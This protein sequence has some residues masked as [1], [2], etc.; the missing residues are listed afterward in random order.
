V[1]V[2]C[3]RD[4]SSYESFFV[5]DIELAEL[6][7]IATSPELEQLLAGVLLEAPASSLDVVRDYWFHAPELELRGSAY[8]RY[9]LRPLAQLLLEADFALDL[10][11][12]HGLPHTAAGARLAQWEEALGL[13]SPD[14]LSLAR[15]QERAAGAIVLV[16]GISRT[17]LAAHATRVLR[18]GDRLQV[19]NAVT[20]I[21]PDVLW[22]GETTDL[23]GG[24]ELAPAGIAYEADDISNV[25]LSCPWGRRGL[26][27]GHGLGNKLLAPSAAIANVGTSPVAVVLAYV[28]RHF[29]AGVAS[30]LA[31]NREGAG[32]NGWEIHISSTGLFRMLLDDG[33]NQT[34]VSLGT[35]SASL[36]T[37]HVAA[38]IFDGA[39]LTAA[40]ELATGSGA[41]AFS[42]SSSSPA[43]LGAYGATLEVTANWDSLAWGVFRGAAKV[44]QIAAAPQAFCQTIHAAI[45]NGA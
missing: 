34:L 4:G 8:E 33:P 35:G 30:L 10:R 31:G 41:F 32:L 20:R 38:L 6:A 14:G 13:A 27:L 25:A 5:G 24:A 11:R 44:S 17:F 40:S 36:N 23:V 7:A 18:T 45:V 16:E 15:R 29:R 26:A 9:R 43:G 22:L 1:T 37:P 12:R 3:R 28:L 39:T 21:E 19:L 42:P 2:G